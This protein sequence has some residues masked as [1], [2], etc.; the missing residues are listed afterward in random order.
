[1]AKLKHRQMLTMENQG[2][3]VVISHR[4]IPEKQQEYENWL[5]EIGPIAQK[6]LGHIDWQIIRPIKNLTFNYTVIIRFDTTENLK[7]WMESNQRKKLIEKV[8][9]LF[10]D[11]DTYYIK[12][13]LDFLFSA[14]NKSAKSPLRWKQY[15]VTWSAI[16]PL[17]VLIPVIVL[18]M[19]KNLNFPEN[20]YLDSL[21]V[22][23]T[24]VFIMVYL[25]MPTYTKLIKNWLYK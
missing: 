10:A 19:L 1:M 21:F 11:N 5:T 13:G 12:S 23:G 22:S 18:P 8:K 6:S 9:P 7:N 15:L 3:T 25:L 14:E 4:I 17:S 16:Y 24:I 2:A 20:R